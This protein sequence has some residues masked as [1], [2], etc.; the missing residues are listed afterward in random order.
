MLPLSRR[1]LFLLIATLASPW[2]AHAQATHVLVEGQRFDRRAVVAGTELG[3][4]GA[5]RGE[6]IAGDDFYET[7]LRSFIGERPYDARLKAGLLGGA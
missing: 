6:A 1:H 4:N 2:M 5:L 7:L 3:L